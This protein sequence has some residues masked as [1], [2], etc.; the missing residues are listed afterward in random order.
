M[1]RRIL[2]LFVFVALSFTAVPA[3]AQGDLTCPNFSSD[4][5][6]A[7]AY[8]EAGGGSATNNYQGMDA[9][10]NGIACDEPGAFEGG[11]PSAGPSGPSAGPSGPS[12]HPTECTEFDTQA[13][14][15]TFLDGATSAGY[16]DVE[17]LDTNGNGIACDESGAGG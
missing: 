13:A 3:G 9:D 1:R 6:A 12:A 11:G 16:N 2:A 5:V 17:Q 15:Q 10:G 7:Q 14:A 4:Q 8:F